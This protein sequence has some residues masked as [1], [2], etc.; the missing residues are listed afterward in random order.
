[1]IKIEEISGQCRLL[2]V[3]EVARI[4]QVTRATIYGWICRR[5][6]PHMEVGLLVRVDPAHIS[7]SF[8]I[9]TPW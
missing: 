5:I 9:A 4:V 3:N 2:T 8:A 7:P 6:L 1:M